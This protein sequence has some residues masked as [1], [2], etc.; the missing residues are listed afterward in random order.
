M[1]FLL[2]VSDGLACFTVLQDAGVHEAT[3]TGGGAASVK[4]SQFKA[5]NTILGNLKTALAGTYHAF[6]FPKYAHRYLAQVQYLFNRRFNLRTILTRLAR[7]ACGTRPCP[8]QAIR[9]AEPS[10]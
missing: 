8:I 3:I 7:A 6:G 5:A 9:A 10:C 1:V 2:V 4:L